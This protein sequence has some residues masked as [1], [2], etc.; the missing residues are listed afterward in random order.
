MKNEAAANAEEDKA[1]REKVD[2]VNAA[3]T[4]I[5]QTE[6]QLTDYGDKIPADKK[7]T[8]EKAVADLKEAHKGED[9][10]K[11]DEATKAL[12]EAWTAASQDI[13]KAQQEAGATADPGAGAPDE[14]GTDAGSEAEDVT[15]VE[16]EEVDDNKE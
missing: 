10:A 15:D 1:A 13:Y 16:F 11:L 5:F 12:N 3:D 9:M 14:A 2:K 4:L 8:I 6:K 7:E